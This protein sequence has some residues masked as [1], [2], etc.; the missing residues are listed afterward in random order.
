MQFN[1]LLLLDTDKIKDYVFASSKL[2]EIRGASMILEYLNTRATK[3]LILNY[4][5]LSEDEV[6]QNG[7]FKIIYLDGGSGKI[8][9]ASKSDAKKC[10]KLIEALYLDWTKT[11]SISWEVVEIDHNE[12]FLSVSRG[13][14]N[15]RTKKQK[16]SNLGQ[17]DHIGIVHRCSRNGY[18]MVENINQSFYEIDDIENTYRKYSRNKAGEF[19]KIGPSSVIKTTYYE[20]N[21][22]NNNQI[23]N[24]H[25]KIED[26]F[27]RGNFSWPKHL[28]VIGDA[29]GNNEIGLLYFDGNSM[30]KV[31]KALKSSAE[32]KQFSHKLNEAIMNSLVDTILEV[33]PSD[34]LPLLFNSDDEDELLEK[35][36]ILPI[37]LI[38]NAGDDIIVV[39][40]S[41]KAMEFASLFLKKF[42][43]GTV[44]ITEH[45][46]NGLTMS[47]GIAISKA[48]FPIKYLVPL[49][50]QLLK[51]A[52]KKNYEL[53]AK[54]VS[55][56]QQ[57]STLD[58]MV[59]SMSSNPNLQVI[60]NEQLIR[61]LENKKAYLTL[62]PYTFDQWQQI[63]EIIQRM[64]SSKKPFPTSKMKSFYHLHFI[65]HWEGSYYF[66]KYFSKL[67]DQKENINLLYRIFNDKEEL[68]NGLWLEDHES[69]SSPLID[70]FE[71]YRYVEG[72]ENNAKH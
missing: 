31:L 26:A 57:L 41:I 54:G 52:K 42:A 50:E 32:Y 70:V 62:R 47:A 45:A 48:S 46:K 15:L 55:D 13:E 68:N 39:V 16:G 11:A 44:G 18:E 34:D 17:G 58:Y 8:E 59:V 9:F 4:F 22:K 72:G 5:H 56:W 60:R 65:E 43:L 36:I 19:V 12:Y 35:E 23:G 2:K 71:I 1:Y 30:N 51:S 14:F 25:K 3:E 61:N 38:M 20:T 29:A 24:L 27:G 63:H 10:G 6:E 40:P 37:E 66:N 69:F 53:K 33:F 67:Q 21:K 28:S 7:N 49:A 64:K